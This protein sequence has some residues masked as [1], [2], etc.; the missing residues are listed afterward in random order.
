MSWWIVLLVVAVVLALVWLG[1][2]TTDQADDVEDYRVRA[3][4]HVVRRRLDV[5]QFRGELKR[6]VARAR[7]ELRR[8]L[9]RLDR[10]GRGR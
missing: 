7:R 10:E 1:R 4:L 3:E 5:A 2:G 8:E 6:D 9:D